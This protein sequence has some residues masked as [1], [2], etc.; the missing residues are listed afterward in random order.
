MK[1]TDLGSECAGQGL[2]LPL[3]VLEKFRHYHY[4]VCYP[5]LKKLI[6][7]VDL[8]I[9]HLFMFDYFWNV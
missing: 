2:G 6:E 8:K 9:Y 3:V 4:Y 5:H 1:R 7:L